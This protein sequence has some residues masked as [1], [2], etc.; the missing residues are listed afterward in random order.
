M[1]PIRVNVSLL[2][3]SFT[4]Y[5]PAL[6]VQ[7][8]AWFQDSREQIS[9]GLDG[10]YY[11]Q[12]KTTEKGL[13]SWGGDNGRVKV[14]SPAGSMVKGAGGESHGGTIPARVAHQI[15]MEADLLQRGMSYGE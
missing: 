12:P 2:G 4:P 7:F 1:T 3:V 6:I 5:P 15:K 11:V 14:D 13:N 10:C 9:N 8:T